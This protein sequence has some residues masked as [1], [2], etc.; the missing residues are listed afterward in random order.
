MKSVPP[1]TIYAA[2]ARAVA[3]RV[4]GALASRFADYLELT[5]PRI[6][7]LALLTVMVGYTLGAADHWRLAPLLHALAGV[8]LVAAGSS[9]L[10]QFLEWR[11]DALMRRTASRPL[12][13]GRIAPIEALAFGSAL[14]IAGVAY[15]A[16]RVNALTAALSAATLVLYVFAYTPAKRTTG[17]CTTIGAIPGAM[18]PVLGWAAA[19]GALDHGALALFG[20]LFLWQFPHFL[21]IGW[22]YRDEYAGAGLKMLPAAGRSARIVGLLSVGYALALVPI[23]L[24][25]TRLALAGD[26]YFLAATLLGAAYAA[27]AVRFLVRGTQG[28]ARGLLWISLVYLPLVLL[29]LTAD[30]LRLTS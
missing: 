11:T 17:L 23:S 28:A 19:G 16:L 7:A 24:W 2:P 14:G 1:A 15:L 3:S 6:A 25:P 26:W 22:L 21:A 18:P 20:I 27:G 5:K 29:A 13:S 12:P 30:Y 10:N 9:A 4:R 8:A